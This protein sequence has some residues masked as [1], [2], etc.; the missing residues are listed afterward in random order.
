ML[1][2][3]NLNKK[4]ETG[5]IILN[6]VCLR[7]GPVKQP[8]W[9]YSRWRPGLL[10]KTGPAVSTLDKNQEKIYKILQQLLYNTLIM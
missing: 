2:N 7:Q 6:R 5:G 4:I 1:L 10:H 8:N 3:S 9:R